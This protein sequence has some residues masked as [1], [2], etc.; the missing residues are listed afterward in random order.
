[1]VRKDFSEGLS[2]KL[3]NEKD[4]PSRMRKDSSGKGA[5]TAP[6]GQGTS[7]TQG[8]GENQK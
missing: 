4:K 6:R 8:P 1:M 5:H 7:S 2:L 3:R